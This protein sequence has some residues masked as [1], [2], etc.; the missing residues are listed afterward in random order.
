[1]LRVALVGAGYIA[2][3]RHL[4]IWEDIDNAEVVAIADLDEAAVREAAR[5]HEI[6]DYFTDTEEMLVEVDPDVVD[7]CT[8]PQSHGP[9]GTLALEHDCNVL[10]E[11]PLA[12]TEEQA[13]GLRDAAAESEGKL[14]TVHQMLFYPPVRKARELINSGEIGDVQGMRLLISTPAEKFLLDESSWIHDT[15]G[16]LLEETGPHT[17]YL[18]QAFIGDIEDVEVAGRKFNDVEWADWDDFVVTL[19]GKQATASVRIVHSSN[20]RAAELDVWGNSGRLKIDLQA[21][22]LHRF[23]RDSLDEKDIAV[24]ALREGANQI[25]STVSTGA[26]VLLDEFQS[27]HDALMNEF[28]TAIRQ[29]RSP[30]VTATEAYETVR[31][32]EDAVADLR[33]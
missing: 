33:S 21:M 17:I 15:E 20:Y 9:L 25:G 29:D 26:K 19:T 24:S 10:V 28:A 23:E 5:K 4:P 27:G 11:K 22:T 12:L 32:L 8:P 2:L 6:P 7:I 14:C 30:P 18:S 13:R 3:R 16:G 1:M 31:V